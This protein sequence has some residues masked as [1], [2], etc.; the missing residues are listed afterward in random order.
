MARSLTNLELNIQ[1]HTRDAQS[2]FTTAGA[3]LNLLNREYRKLASAV[4]WPEFLIENTSLTTV[5]GQEAYTW[6]SSANPAAV[7]AIEVE[8]DVG[9]GSKF[10]EAVFGENQFGGELIAYRVVTAPPSEIDWSLVGQLS[11]SD[12][13]LFYRR[14]TSGGTHQL[15]LRPAPSITGRTIK[16]RGMDEPTALTTGT[17]ATTFDDEIGDDILEYVVAAEYSDKNGDT[18]RGTELREK[19]LQL[20]QIYLGQGGAS[21][22]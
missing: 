6:P 12:F 4:E 9:G 2:T 18:D 7:K 1:A 15:L 3:N 20:L 11:N 14:L 13:P 5:A 16:I 21:A 10:G 19:G 17:D 22:S 8:A